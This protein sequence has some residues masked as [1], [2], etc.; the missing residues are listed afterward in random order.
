MFKQEA[1]ST[2]EEKRAALIQN[3]IATLKKPPVLSDQL[4]QYTYRYTFPPPCTSLDVACNRSLILT[5]PHAPPATAN[6]SLALRRR[7]KE[8]KRHV[9]RG[10]SPLVG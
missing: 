9:C 8:A 3:D 4:S 10:R 6:S 1:V 5:P 7:R 2:V